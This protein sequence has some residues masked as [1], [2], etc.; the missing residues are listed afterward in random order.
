M[1]AGLQIAV[2][3]CPW[4]VDTWTVALE[5]RSPDFKDD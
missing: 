4:T 2:E 5:E 1:V 3:K